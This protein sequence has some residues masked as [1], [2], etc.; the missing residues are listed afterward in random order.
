MR[1]TVSTGVHADGDPEQASDPSLPPRSSVGCLPGMLARQ[2]RALHAETTVG[3]EEECHPFR[4]IHR[5]RGSLGDC[6][7]KDGCEEPALGAVKR[8]TP[9]PSLPGVMGERSWLVGWLKRPRPREGKGSP[10]MSGSVT[11][12][13][14]APPS[15]GVGHHKQRQRL[16]WL[17]RPRKAASPTATAGG[18]ASRV[19]IGE[20]HPVTGLRV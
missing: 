9:A 6:S 3:L 11:S 14:L 10:S 18:G 13:R 1:H 8:S 4:R 17:P 12:C 16:P 15:P 19:L 5:S 7:N 20:R 2:D